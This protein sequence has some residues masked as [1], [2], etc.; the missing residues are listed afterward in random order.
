M[1]TKHLHLPVN[2]ILTKQPDHSRKS[3]IHLR[4]HFASKVLFPLMVLIPTKL[5][6][7]PLMLYYL[8]SS[9]EEVAKDMVEGFG[10]VL[11]R[12]TPDKAKYVNVK[13]D[14]TYKPEAYNY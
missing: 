4:L 11:N 9:S 6:A 13:V 8:Q 7:Y 1:K 12:L 5:L 14:G 3:V 10:G 2:Q